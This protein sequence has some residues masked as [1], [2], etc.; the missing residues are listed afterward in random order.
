MKADSAAV[1][2]SSSGGDWGDPS[3]EDG[4]CTAGGAEE[5]GLDVGG[6]GLADGLAVPGDAGDAGGLA[7]PV[8]GDT[9]GSGDGGGTRPGASDV[10]SED[11][12][13]GSEGVGELTDGV[14]GPVGGR[15]G[16]SVFWS[17]LPVSPWWRWNQSPRSG[18]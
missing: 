3:A 12:A 13:E 17:C 16:G 14:G 15:V 7:E 8:G 11:G 2:E 18:S 9:H 6:Q 4:G 1:S 10:G 5:G